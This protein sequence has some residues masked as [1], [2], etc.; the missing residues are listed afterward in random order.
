MI[1]AY[2]DILYDFPSLGEYLKDLNSFDYQIHFD[3]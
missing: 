3:S 2:K 1:I